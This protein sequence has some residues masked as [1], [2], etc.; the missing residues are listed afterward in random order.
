MSMLMSQ[1]PWLLKTNILPLS[2]DENSFHRFPGRQPPLS[3][4][5][6]NVIKY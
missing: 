3:S 5:D 2:K 1:A 6:F 4:A